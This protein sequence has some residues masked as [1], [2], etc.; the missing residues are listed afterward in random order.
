M[1]EIAAYNSAF[2]TA[3]AL[4][5]AKGFKERSH[6]CLGIAIRQLYKDN[7]R[8]MDLINIFDELRV[9]RHNVQYGGALVS[10][11]EAEF[12]LN[13][14]EEFLKNVKDILKV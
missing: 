7:P 5:F 1:V 10:E 11:E 9:S 13:F 4:L 8:I 6:Y 14:I 3:R 2:H 12:V